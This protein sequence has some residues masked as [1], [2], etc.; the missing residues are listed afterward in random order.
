MTD[1]E[2]IR[3]T[4][5][6][7]FHSTEQEL[8]DF[9]AEYRKAAED[10]ETGTKKL[11]YLL[12]QMYVYDA[13]YRDI[14]FR[15]LEDIYQRLVVTPCPKDDE[16]E[17]PLILKVDF[18]LLMFINFDDMGHH[19]RAKRI[20]KVLEGLV[21]RHPEDPNIGKVYIECLLTETIDF[22]TMKE[23]NVDSLIDYI[24]ELLPRYNFDQET[25]DYIEFKKNKVHSDF[26][27]THNIKENE[28]YLQSMVKYAEKTKDI[29]TINV[30]LDQMMGGGIKYLVQC[31]LTLAKLESL[32]ESILHGKEN[33]EK[34]MWNLHTS[35]LKL[36][37]ASKKEDKKAAVEI[38]TKLLEFWNNA[39]LE[40]YCLLNFKILITLL[41]FANDPEAIDQ[42][43]VFKMKKD[44]GNIEKYL[45]SEDSYIVNY[46]GIGLYGTLAQVFQALGIYLDPNIPSKYEKF[47]AGDRE[48][49]VKFI[50]SLESCL[51]I[52]LK[53][54]V[55]KSLE[56]LDE[57]D[58]HK[59]HP[60]KLTLELQLIMVNFMS[61]D[62]V[63]FSVGNQKLREYIEYLNQYRDKY[64]FIGQ[65]LLWGYQALIPITL[66]MNDINAYLK[67][68]PDFIK[69][70]IEHC[71]NK[72]SI[73]D[74]FTTLINVYMSQ[75]D[76]KN[77]MKTAIDYYKYTKTFVGNTKEQVEAIKMVVVI[78][79]SAQ[80]FR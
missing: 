80:D 43:E 23:P 26:Y 61:Q 68:A 44:Y 31:E 11:E 70:G 52:S 25:L 60:M 66:N 13:I 36:G 3:S 79:R 54:A 57:M 5:Q 73:I 51:D 53:A 19:S 33:K 71:E 46:T 45:N 17:F 22:I 20:L 74:A 6:N 28:K 56:Y 64:D 1:I 63:S 15:E 67:Y 78:K 41:V 12:V 77:A 8:Q 27:T 75:Q 72:D 32:L 29:Y 49:Y 62:Q 24:D 35:L 42:A 18:L 65:R 40:K 55:N 50:S 30:T 39:Q 7:C 69:L 76:L 2:K 4:R 38:G 59:L 48:T 14:N 34:N 9:I 16:E 21:E 10:D 58:V 37:L 47:L